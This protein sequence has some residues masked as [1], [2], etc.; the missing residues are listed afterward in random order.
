MYVPG[1]VSL[2]PVDRDESRFAQASRQMFASG[3]WAVPYVQDRPRLNKPPM[4]YWLQCA[5]LW[6]FG[7]R[8]R[9]HEGIWVYRLPSVLCATGSVLLTWRLGR[10]MFDA[11]AAWLGAVFLAVCPIV[12]WDAHQARADQVLLIAVVATQ[13][14]LWRVWSAARGGGGAGWL[15]PMG[16]WA[17][18]GLGILAKG[19]IIPL[20]P[21]L[22]VVGLCV[23][24]RSCRWLMALRPGV[25]VLVAGAMLAPWLIEA[26]REVGWDRLKAI[27]FDETIGRSAGAKE[28]H[29]GPPGYHLVLLA[30][31]LWPGSLM[32][33]AGVVRAFRRGRVRRRGSGRSAELFCLAWVIPAWVVFELVGTKLPHYTM[34]MYPA[35][36]LLS[37]RALL[38]AAAMGPGFRRDLGVRLGEAAWFVIGLC[39][40]VLAPAGL[41]AALAHPEA[42]ARAAWV[43]P[44]ASGVA[45]LCAMLLLSGV[46]GF[47]RGLLVRAQLLGVAAAV[48]TPTALIGVVL[49]HEPAVGVNVRLAAAIRSVDPDATRPIGGVV[50]HEDSMI[51]LTRGRYTRLGEDAWR[52]WLLEHPDGVLVLPEG[53]GAGEAGLR[54]IGRVV[55]FNYSVGRWVRLRVIELEG[56]GR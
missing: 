50:Y 46:A 55:G 8:G 19:P 33:A 54:E 13:L 29:W 47:S 9:M 6:V 44:V 38:S 32:T 23:A 20:V 52:N 18:V 48:L 2:P 41:W 34:P 3:D 1:L 22:T 53:T 27:A 51:F 45:G 24:T 17:C 40:C 4:V 14:C 5:S 25:G 31:L 56:G 36:A 16:F 42:G 43:L 15:W 12:V 21:V 26:A 37:A 10:R 39:V 30:V 35:L 28:G 11:R 49:A 7:D